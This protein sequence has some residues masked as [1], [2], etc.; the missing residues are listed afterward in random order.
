M[1]SGGIDIILGAV[2]IEIPH[3]NSDRKTR[4]TLS[5]DMVMRLEGSVFFK[6]S[7]SDIGCRKWLAARCNIGESLSADVGCY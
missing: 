4:V 7:K 1:D 6:L 5:E 2:R 3:A